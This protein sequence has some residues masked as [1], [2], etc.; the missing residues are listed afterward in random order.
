MSEIGDLEMSLGGAM[1]LFAL[2]AKENVELWTKQDGLSNADVA[3][4]VTRSLLAALDGGC[5]HGS[6]GYFL[7]PM[8]IDFEAER[9]EAEK[10]VQYGITYCPTEDIAGGLVDTYNRVQ[11]EMASGTH[12]PE[13]IEAINHCQRVNDYMLTLTPIENNKTGI[14]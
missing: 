13:L 9:V 6:P 3:E 14:E 2:R 11:S 4:G 5:S 10:H 7:M 1:S 12:G 8:Q